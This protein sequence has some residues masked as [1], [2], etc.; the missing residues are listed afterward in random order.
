MGMH[1]CYDTMHSEMASPKQ[2]QL[3][4]QEV[5]D[6]ADLHIPYLNE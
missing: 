3:R 2:E 6:P 5:L 1:W 4:S